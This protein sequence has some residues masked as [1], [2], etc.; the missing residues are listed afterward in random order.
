MVL[1][2]MEDNKYKKELTEE[3]QKKFYDW[4]QTFILESGHSFGQGMFVE[5]ITGEFFL[6]HE[7][8]YQKWYHNKLD[9]Y[10]NN[11]I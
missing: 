8:K 2:N 11:H 7:D 4:L 6:L 10:I 3:E 1:L 9:E 5:L